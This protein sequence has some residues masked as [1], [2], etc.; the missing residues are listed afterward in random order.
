M[1]EY[2]DRDAVKMLININFSGLLATIDSIP[3]A[4][5]APVRHGRWER[6]ENE[7]NDEAFS[8]TGEEA[9]YYW[10]CSVCHEE[11]RKSVGRE[12]VC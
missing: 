7:S 1:A 11:D 8:L 6:S 3:T 10:T 9:W 12:R 2:I 4:D 5:V